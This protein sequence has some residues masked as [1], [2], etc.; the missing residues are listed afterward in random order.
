[1]DEDGCPISRSIDSGLERSTNARRQYMWFIGANNFRSCV[2]F[3]ALPA[4]S[5]VC[6][7]SSAAEDDRRAPVAALYKNFAWQAF[8]DDSKIFGDGL[9]D[10]SGSTLKKYFDAHLAT[11]IAGDA[12]CKQRTGELCKIDF[13][14]L[15]HSQDPRIADLTITA[16]GD[17]T[18][19]VRFSDPVTAAETLIRYTMRR[20]SD[21]WR[22]YD[23]V[24]EGNAHRSLRSMLAPAVSG[25]KYHP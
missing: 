1:M 15:F 7:T 2:I 6:S 21:G 17:H 19:A 20:Q 4:L 22:I 10:Q 14:I 23:V 3:C 18:V 5:A 13:D 24:Y 25:K 8:S 9:S 12:A 11:L 16:S